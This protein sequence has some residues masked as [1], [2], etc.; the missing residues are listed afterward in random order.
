MAEKLKILIDTDPGL[1]ARN[2]DVDDGIAILL[3][4]ASPELEVAGV[5][6]VGGNV[7]RDIGSLN[8][9]RLLRRIGRKD[10]PFAP[11]SAEPV[12][13]VDTKLEDKWRGVEVPSPTEEEK[14]AL[15]R[16]K[17][18]NGTAVDFILRSIEAFGDG[19]TLVALGPLTNLGLAA[20][21]APELFG[22]VRQIVIMGG[23]ARSG[24]VSATAEFNLWCD[25]E[26]ADVVFRSGIQVVMFGLDI[27]TRIEVVPQV[28]AGWSE[29]GGFLRFLQE[30]SVDYMHFR[31]QRYGR[32]HP[33]MYYHDAMP[34]A[35]LADPLLFDTVPCWVDVEKTGR[36]TRGMTVVDQDGRFHGGSTP[37][38]LAS[39]IRSEAFQELLLGRI[40]DTYRG[41]D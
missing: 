17:A 39:E 23:S 10:I 21:Q 35:W 22:R 3:A 31:S 40:Q 18:G 2:T 33:F 27:T 7:P 25:P 9:L 37:H 11:G 8:I 5:T 6:T 19:L 26:A 36:Y 20:A 16:I 4:L 28:I 41:I 24:N 13:G 15:L 38:R 34:V 14:E 12:G 30:A 1:G 29:A 32:K